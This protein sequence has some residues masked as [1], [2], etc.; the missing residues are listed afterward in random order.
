[1]AS[2]TGNGAYSP[3]S[4]VTREQAFTILR[5]A[6]PLLGKEC[7]T[8]SLAVLEQF[9]DRHLI[10][11][12]AKGHT[13][14]LVAQGVVS[15]KGEGIDPK[16]NLTRAEMAALL[17]KLITYTPI[18][19]YPAQPETPVLTIEPTE[20]ALNS[21]GSQTI[22]A[23]LTPAVE[24]SLI[25]WTSDNT[26]A[27]VVNG[28]GVV[29]NINPTGETVT[30]TITAAWEEQT[31]QCTVTCGPAKLWGTVTGAENGLNVRSGPGTDASVVGGVA[32]ESR[33]VVLSVQEGWCHIL[34]RNKAGQAAV[35][36]V[37]GDYLQLSQ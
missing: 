30:V 32:N 33:V 13:A 11:D 20:L 36:Y 18:T 8:G 21:A 28:D 16:G 4:P 31:A 5:Q 37:S 35:G 6:M 29:T 7:P 9:A 10:A 34:Y 1:M 25:T 24:R 15:G 17:Y 19:E 14:T 12:Y 27:A 26:D 22:T 3:A 23:V 2:G